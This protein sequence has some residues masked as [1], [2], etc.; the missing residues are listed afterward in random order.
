M[1]VTARGLI[2]LIGINRAF[3]SKGIAWFAARLEYL[4]VGRQAIGILS[5]LWLW[6][7]ASWRWT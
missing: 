2:P 3:T 5:S 4:T 6:S 1:A 7:T